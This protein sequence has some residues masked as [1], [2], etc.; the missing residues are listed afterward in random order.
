MAGSDGRPVNLS[1]EE[2]A[3]GNAAVQNWGF[4]IVAS[5]KVR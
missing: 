4:N 3:R 2:A 1:K 5:N